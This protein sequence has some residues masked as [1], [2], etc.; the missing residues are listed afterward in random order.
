MLSAENN[1]VDI[2]FI[3]ENKRGS[4]L[5][6]VYRDLMSSNKDTPIII[7]YDSKKFPNYNN[8][9]TNYHFVNRNNI[10]SQYQSMSPPIQNS[11]FPNSN[12]SSNVSKNFFGNYGQQDKNIIDSYNR[13]R[14]FDPNRKNMNRNNI[15]KSSNNIFSYNNNNNNINVLNRK[16]FFDTITNFGKENYNKMNNNNEEENYGRNKYNY[17]ISSYKPKLSSRNILNDDNKDNNFFNYNNENN[18]QRNN[19]NYNIG[20]NN[21]RYDSYFKNSNGNNNNKNNNSY[22]YNI[23]KYNKEYESYIKN[24]IGNNNN[25]NN[26]SYDY[27]IP[28]YNNG[29]DNYYKNNNGNNNSKN[30]SSYDYN[31]PKYNNGYDNYYKNNNGNN[32]NKNSNSYDYNI[33]KYNNGYESYFKNN[34]GNNNRR[35]N[36]FSIKD[37]DNN[38]KRSNQGFYSKSPE[39]NNLRSYDSKNNLFLKN[40]ND[41]YNPIRRSSNFEDSSKRLFKDYSLNNIQNRNGYNNNK[42]KYNITSYSSSTMAGTNGLGVTKTNQ[43]SF[44]IKIDKNNNNENV[45]TFGVFD[46]HGAEG[47]LVS[48]AIKKFF[49]SKDLNFNTKSNICSIFS[50]LSE[51]INNANYFDNVG[52]GSTVVLVHINPEKIISINCGDSRAILITKKNNIISLTRD[53]KPELP[54][55]RERIEASGGR[56][57]KIYGMGPY[58][59]WFK[60][61]DIP[62]LAMSRSIGDKLAHKVGVSDEPEIKE[63][64]DIDPLAVIVASDGVWEFMSNEEVKNILMN[65]AHSKDAKACSKNIVEKARH[66]WEDTDYAIDDITCVVGFFDD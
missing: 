59:V 30:N 8:N 27:N 51:E 32:N 15:N 61:E 43:D 37:N 12:L 14:S 56:I 55:E 66:V 40:N 11:S 63:F 49:R 9:P 25:K 3:N 18:N 28:K 34:N 7:E 64:Y 24:F 46:G 23:A 10:R 5:S 54:D 57:D 1:R 52:S 13:N 38:N 60:D 62:G 19:Y 2:R 50:S 48:Q 4:S 22:N 17:S 42:K 44:I 36:N 29:Y 6:N 41:N 45:Y 31:I 53:H 20:K 21:N 33:D 47:H 16:N 35:Y 65:Y 39:I 26:N 58:R